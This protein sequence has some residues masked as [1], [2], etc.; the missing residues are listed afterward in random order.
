MINIKFK[1]IRR[2]SVLLLFFV[3]FAGIWAQIP[4]G[5]YEEAKEKSG[6]EL[7]TTLHNIIKDHVQQ[8]YYSAASFFERYDRTSN[9]YI[10]DMYSHVKFRMFL[11]HFNCFRKPWRYDHKFNRAYNAVCIGFYCTN[12]RGMCTSNIVSSYDEILR[13][14]CGKKNNTNCQKKGFLDHIR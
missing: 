11:Q 13:L 1:N 10:W 9:G 8:R 3:F 2:N 5:Y 4:A 12:V 7:K 6:K 14:N